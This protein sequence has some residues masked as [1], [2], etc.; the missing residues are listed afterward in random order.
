MTAAPPATILLLAEDDDRHAVAA[1]EALLRALLVHVDPRARPE[2]VRFEPG[3]EDARA[4][5]NLRGFTDPRRNIDRA[6]LH[7][8]ILGAL[9]RDDGFVVVHV[10]AE[11][12][13][14]DR[15]ADPS[16]RLAALQRHVVAHVR[17]GLEAAL[18]RREPGLDDAE[19]RLRVE[20]RMGRLFRLVTYW[21]LE[22]WLYQNT[23]RA[24]ALC[25]ANPACRGGHVDLLATW[26]ADRGLLDETPHAAGQLCF[27]RPRLVRLLDE[28]PTSDVVAAGK[29][30]AAFVDALRA[31]DALLAALRATHR[32][33]D[34]TAGAGDRQ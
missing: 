23:A 11:R 29:S 19:L 34:D 21:Q 16:E 4:V 6:R 28:F 2:L 12:R 18:R 25:L 8:S 7:R 32:P 3:R 14:S 24:R 10:D 13:W 22:S 33:D 17:V 20:A 9:L 1:L 5:V 27:G 30:L 31:S 26:A 15:A